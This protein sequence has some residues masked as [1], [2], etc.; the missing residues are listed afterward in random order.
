MNF[1]LRTLAIFL[2]LTLAGCAAHRP[3][4]APPAKPLSAEA[5]LTYDYLLYLDQRSLLMAITQS[6]PQPD[7]EDYDL[8]I[9]V[10]EIAADALGKVIA[11][12]PS[13]MLYGEL[14]SLYFNPHQVQTAL[15][16][17]R[18]GLGLY[19]D[20]RTLLGLTVNANLLKNDSEMA[21][22]TLEEYL[23]TNPDDTEARIRLVTILVEIK[24]YA[25]ALDQIEKIPAADRNL[26][27]RYL[28]AR[29]QSRI[30]N[31][32]EAK[33]TLR[34]I[35][36]EAP[37][38]Y[39][40]LTE[41]AF[42]QELEADFL[43]AI[44][45]Y[46]TL[47]KLGGPEPEILQ[48]IITLNLKLNRVD[49][50]LKAALD[51]PNTKSF[52]LQAAGLFLNQDFP[53]QAS[54]VL[55][56]LGALA[57][58]PPEYYFYKAVIAFDAESDPTKALEFLNQVQPDQTNYI[59]ALIFRVQIL[60]DMGRKDEAMNLLHEGRDAFPDELK[61]DRML[62]E[63]LALEDKYIEAADIL[64]Q[65]I[66]RHGDNPELLFQYGALLDLQGRRDEAIVIMERIIENDPTNA[67][68]LNYVGYTLAEEGRDLDRAMV[69]IENALL[70]KPQNGAITD[71]LA[72]VFFK[73][74]EIEKAWIHIK[75]AVGLMDKDP[76]IWEHYGDIAK[77]KSLTKEALTGYTNALKF[78]TKNAEDI[79]KKIDS[80]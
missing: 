66:N 43:D 63:Y 28:K 61:F 34:A 4:M 10:Q 17:L 74:G 60:M 30:G 41:L 49:A 7:T 22:L 15:D 67:E 52:L 53:A 18:Q 80:L 42:I 37:D 35:L 14:A 1:A 12:E 33:K 44:R 51:G 73:Q 45:T 29:A 58:V 76:V 26:S 19:P 77:A 16:I 47:L 59:Q 40:S 46:T 55:D 25:R 36:K 57:P 32:T 71:S 72:W 69:L 27:V 62:A 75:D 78:K 48:R 5:Q 2:L 6:D 9:A 54:A 70:Q 65:A 24:Q 31:R 23:L 64:E 11:K 20:D 38:H 56:R 3:K 13:A 50:A 68:A 39:E 21:T 8:A 79:Q